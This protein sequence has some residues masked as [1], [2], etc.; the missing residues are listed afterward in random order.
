MWKALTGFRYPYRISEDAELERQW[1]DGGWR[2]LNP[3]FSVG[4][5]GSRGLY[6]NMAVFPSGHKRMAIT[7]LMALAGWIPPKKPGQ[8]YWHKNRCA[9]DCSA[10]NLE[11]IS[12][13]EKGKRQNGPGRRAVVKIDRDGNE[14]EVYRSVTEAAK[15]N[16]VDRGVVTARCLGE[17]QNPF[18][19]LGVSF[20]YET[21][22]TVTT[23]TL[24]KLKELHAQGLVDRET[25]RELGISQ[26]Q[27]RYYRKS[28]GLPP[29]R[30]SA[31][32]TVY[33]RDG[34]VLAFGTSKE[35]AEALGIKAESIRTVAS[36]TKSGRME[37]R[38]QVVREEREEGGGRSG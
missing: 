31:S 32:Y 38:R 16:H 19:L 1:P 34:N 23:Q 36:K 33:D 2:R 9:Q 8:I 12:A 28:L 13:S 26:S 25:A 22:P 20:R 14:L 30:Y 21:K 35:C 17:V 11:L 24:R 10:R 18:D 15:A 27:A 4:S 5:D 37:G 29:N 7:R 3:Y 6:V